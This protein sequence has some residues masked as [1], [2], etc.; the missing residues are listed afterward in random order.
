MEVLTAVDNLITVLDNH[1]VTKLLKN[2]R[3]EILA[4]KLLMEELR[5]FKNLNEQEYLKNKTK[6]FNNKKIT[7]YHQSLN[8]FNYLLMN[9]NQQLAKIN[10]QAKCAKVKHE[11]Y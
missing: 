5:N 2:Q 11:N 1:D 10:Q 9:I 4:D 8:E 6:I 3:K 7:A